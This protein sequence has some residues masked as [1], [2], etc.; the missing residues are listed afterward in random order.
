MWRRTVVGGILFARDHRLWVEE[1]PVGAGLDIVDGTWLEVDVER[2][3]YVLA[4][5]SLREE[6]RETAVVLRLA[7]LDKTTIWL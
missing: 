4:R 1:R 6:S 2:P 5:A 3:R 7:S